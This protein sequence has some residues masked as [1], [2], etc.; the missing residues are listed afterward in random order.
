MSEFYIYIRDSV[1]ADSLYFINFDRVMTEEVTDDST[2][3]ERVIQFTRP[4]TVL[5][6]GVSTILQSMRVDQ[7]GVYVGINQDGRHS[8]IPLNK[9]SDWDLADLPIGKYSV[10]IDSKQAQIDLQK[11]DFSTYSLR[12]T[13]ESNS[14]ISYVIRDEE[15]AISG[16][17]LF[18][19][20][21][22]STPVKSLSRAAPPKPTIY[23]INGT[24][25]TSFGIVSQDEELFFSAHY[26]NYQDTIHY[27]TGP[28][29]M[30][31]Q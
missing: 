16:D 17:T 1:T 11:I 26:F 25:Y 24:K 18:V 30:K 8:E 13:D 23:T 29:K 19:F 31:R 4:E 3:M 22:E 14:D 12:I 2:E 21:T 9:R 7:Q 6:N 20:T 5:I 15:P 27:S 28:L 10:D